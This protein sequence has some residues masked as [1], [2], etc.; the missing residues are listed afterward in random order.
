MEKYAIR[1]VERSGLG[2]SITAA[3]WFVGL[4]GE[5]SP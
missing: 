3:D 5:A 1:R 2:G 4:I